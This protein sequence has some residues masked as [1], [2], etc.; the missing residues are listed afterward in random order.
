MK[1]QFQ[2]R[3]IPCLKT[4]CHQYLSQEQTQEVRIPD[5]MPDIGSILSSW[6]Q[7]IIR[8]KEWHNGNAGVN[9]GVMVWVLYLPEDG[10]QVQQMETW[11][12]FQQSW[13]FPDTNPDGY[14][15]VIPML[16]SVD[17][18]TL[19]ARKMM[20]RA[21]VGLVGQATVNDEMETFI[22]PEL[23]EDVKVNMKTYPICLPV[24]T[25]EKA[26]HLEETLNLPNTAVPVDKILRYWMEPNLSEWKVVSDKVIVRGIATLGVLYLGTDGQLHSWDTELP[27]SQYAQLSRDY[28]SNVQA[29]I[30]FVVTNLELEIG[31]E[32]TLNLKAGI[33][34]QY[35]IYDTSM[36][37]IADDAYSPRREI[38][39]NRERI[40]I[41]AILD[42]RMDT[43]SAEQ[44]IPAD[45]LRVVDVSF[46]PEN[47]IIQRQGDEING[48][49]S[50]S[51]QILGY[52]PEGE[53][54]TATSRWEDKMPMDV[55]SGAGIEMTA[56]RA[57]KPSAIIGAGDVS[58][59]APM[60]LKTNVTMGQ[61]MEILSGL[62]LGDMFEPDPNRPSIILRRM[63]TDSLWDI[64]KK[65]GSTVETIQNINNLQG[66]KPVDQMLL[67]PV[68]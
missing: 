59:H 68:L 19:T 49:L 22:P 28:E 34:G 33:T 26:F 63:G 3:V 45:M 66:E 40:E 43:V 9:G 8:G 4:V 44:K 55:D 56:Q 30:L 47:P 35:T 46:Y 17:A 18:R 15:Q 29:D 62:E 2:K 51:F 6:G 54:Q 32:N 58:V 13:D 23:P 1:I 38:T 50:G 20:V 21:S 36:V 25:G 27:F 53:L 7:I 10:G 41:P 57:G 67:I 65:S 60:Q 12:P 24:E 5:G 14:L 48:N 42:N 11:L 61:G 31:E 16:R 52:T 64:A 39:V 37:E